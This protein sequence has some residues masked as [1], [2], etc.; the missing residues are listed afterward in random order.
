MLKFIMPSFYF[1]FLFF[2]SNSNV[3]HR[4]VYVKCFSGTTAHRILEFGTN[5]GYDY[6]YYVR[7][8]QHPHSY[9]SIYS[10]IFLFL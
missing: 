7:Q 8:N 3:M 10:S 1:F 5:L 6:L 4:E 2:I 9:H